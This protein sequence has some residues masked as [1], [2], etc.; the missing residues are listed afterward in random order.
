MSVPR[1]V[2]A[3]LSDQVTLEVEGIDRM[4]LYVYIPGLC[5]TVQLS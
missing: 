1:S 2:A 3:V 5:I 4:Y